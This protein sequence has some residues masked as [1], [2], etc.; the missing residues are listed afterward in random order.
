MCG[1]F[2]YDLE[3]GSQSAGWTDF[4]LV[5]CDRLSHKWQSA[6]HLPYF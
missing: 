5:T 4:N 6:A 2:A 3:R 1:D